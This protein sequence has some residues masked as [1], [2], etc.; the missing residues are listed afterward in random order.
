MIPGKSLPG[1]SE[2]GT[3]TRLNP[4]PRPQESPAPITTPGRGLYFMESP[5][6]EPLTNFVPWTSR[7][8]LLEF[9]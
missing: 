6:Y 9:A 4:T 8:P 2:S 3:L 5:H 7:N 1:K